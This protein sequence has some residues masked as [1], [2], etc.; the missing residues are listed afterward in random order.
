MNQAL[1]IFRKDVRRLWPLITL[2][3]AL[4]ASV[5]ADW[6]PRSGPPGIG[7]GSVAGGASFGYVNVGLAPLLAL[8]PILSVPACW[9]LAARVVQ[10]EPLPGERQFWLT[11]PYDRLS[12]LLAKVL[13]LS[14]FVLLP[15][16]FMGGAGEAHIGVPVLPNIGGLLGW[17]IVSGTWLI[18]PGVAIAVVTSSLSGFVGALLAV[19]LAIG[20]YASYGTEAEWFG[21]AV[22]APGITDLAGYLPM[23]FFAIGA[24]VL[25]YNRRKTAWS[26]GLLAAALLAPALTLP[27]DGLVSLATRLRNPGFD[28]AQ[29]H[30]AFDQSSPPRLEGTQF[31]QSSCESLRLKVDGLPKGASLESFGDLALEIQPSKAGAKIALSRYPSALGEFPDGFREIFCVSGP[32]YAA[33]KDDTLTL[34]LSLRATVRSTID[35]IRV[36][37]SGFDI[38]LGN[39]GHCDSRAPAGI[40]CRLAMPVFDSLNAGVEYEGYKVYSTNFVSNQYSF[41]FPES[42]PAGAKAF[43]FFRPGWPP[44]RTY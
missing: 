24:I 43:E 21:A 3:W 31:P 29:V 17:G 8:L 38:E 4:F 16:I 13:F 12:L 39:A 11:R 5:A 6:I 26:L 22:A 41:S 10:Q 9:I 7:A 33:L 27:A 15:H 14:V 35:E 37:Y 44:S 19:S 30:I 2:V 23:I 28:P 32:P 1:H 20:V 18:L 25:Q 36:P 42:H 34:R 40:Y